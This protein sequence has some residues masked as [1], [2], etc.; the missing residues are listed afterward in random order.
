MYYFKN[1]SICCY[2]FIIQITAAIIC[3]FLTEHHVCNCPV[4]KHDKN[5]EKLT[6][7]YCTILYRY[8]SCLGLFLLSCICLL[9]LMQRVGHASS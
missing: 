9:L 2:L 7:L 5:I 4:V 8:C 6:T 1:T 3:D